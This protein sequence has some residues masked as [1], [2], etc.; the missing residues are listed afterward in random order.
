[1]HRAAALLASAAV[2]A[3]VAGGASGAVASRGAQSTWPSLST[4]GPFLLADIQDKVDGHWR[5][6]WRTLFPLHR[7]VAPLRTY[8]R[9]ERET[10]F[11]LPLH[12]VHVAA[13]RRTT[14]HVPGVA[15]PVAGV[16]VTVHVEL[17]WYGPRDPI[18]FAHTFHLV[19]VDGRWT[20]LL[21]PGRYRLYASG[22]C[23]APSM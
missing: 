3:G 23:G 21:S 2:A 1:M 9:C 13:V 10:P 17:E 14:V 19:P 20:W 15:Q 11:A 16:A 4:A 12:A 6:A 22:G 5:D 8:V 7:A 18:V